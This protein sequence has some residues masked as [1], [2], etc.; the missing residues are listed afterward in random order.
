MDA[1]LLIGLVLLVV[2]GFFAYQWVS[3]RNR[4]Q[5]SI[6][7][8]TARDAGA[9]SVASG[10]ESPSI[11][12]P[13]KTAQPLTTAPPKELPLPQVAGQTEADLRA[14]EPAQQRVPAS[15]QQPVT[16]DGLGP[17]EFD[18]TLRHPEQLFHQPQGQ[19]AVPT[20]QVSDVPSGRAAMGST[21][22]GAHE[23]PFSPEYAQ[24]GGA[25]I[26]NSVFA[27]DGME[28]NELTNF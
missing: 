7:K 24:N 5:T 28:S 23:Q 17:A 22:L 8:K 6:S 18:S 20:M 27:Y 11:E 16:H 9:V 19:A 21:P 25:L 13:A 10:I 12:A 26:G 3:K 2:V 14:K 1:K 4:R 15:T